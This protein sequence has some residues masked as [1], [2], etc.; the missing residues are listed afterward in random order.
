MKEIKKILIKSNCNC[1]KAQ[2]ILE[3]NFSLDRTH[4]QYFLNN[5]F[6]EVKSYTNVG[7]L[8]IEDAS[9]AAIGPFGSNRLQIKCKNPKCDASLAILENVLMNI[10]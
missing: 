9:L 6:T 4:I 8:Y 2:T 1:S 7:I 3:M 10:P 5:N